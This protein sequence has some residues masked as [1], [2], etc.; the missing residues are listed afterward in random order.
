MSTAEF[1]A[2]C[3]AMDAAGKH[4]AMGQPWTTW[5]VATYLPNGDVARDSHR[6]QIFETQTEFKARQHTIP[7]GQTFDLFA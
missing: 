7:T 1:V 3:E 5:K 6:R 4:D 2:W